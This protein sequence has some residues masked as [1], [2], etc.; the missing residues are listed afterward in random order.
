[1]L[2]GTGYAKGCVGLGLMYVNEQGVKQDYFKAK[3]LFGKACDG[4]YAIGCKNY[5]ILN[6]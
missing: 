3:E 2:A 5:A 4:G 1:V 6:K